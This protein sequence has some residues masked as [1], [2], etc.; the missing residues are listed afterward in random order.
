MESFVMS[1]ELALP[2]RGK[3]FGVAAFATLALG[4]AA[5]VLA[6]FHFRAPESVVMQSPPEIKVVE[7]VVHVTDPRPAPP[8]VVVLPPPPPPPV[9]A[10]PPPPPPPA[11]RIEV[12]EVWNGIWRRK[13]SPLPMFKLSQ[14]GDSV[15]GTCAPN[16]SAV[17]PISGGSATEKTAEFV[18]DDQV[19]R[20]HVRMTMTGENEATVEQCVTDEDWAAS[21]VRA[22]QAVR[23]PQQALLA[24]AKLEMDARK[25]RKPVKV[26]TFARGP[27]E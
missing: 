6:I 26:G 18:V 15:A 9:V 27:G 25:F 7:K 3:T 10:P 13:E 4:M 11:A 24:R 12:K 22:M 19:F 17:L 23:T 1:S 14:S 21:L 5:A 2:Q 16:W 20:V 8:P